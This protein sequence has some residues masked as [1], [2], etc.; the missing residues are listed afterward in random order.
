[1]T[2]KF[3]RRSAHSLIPFSEDVWNSKLNGT[4]DDPTIK[5]VGSKPTRNQ[6]MRIIGLNHEGGATLRP[7]T[8]L[9]TFSSNLYHLHSILKLRTKSHGNS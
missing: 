5:L 4:S 8:I 7:Q 3:A 2:P 1:V 6:L 9:A